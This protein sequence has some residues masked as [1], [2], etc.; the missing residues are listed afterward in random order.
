MQVEQMVTYTDLEHIK[1]QESYWF[2]RRFKGKYTPHINHLGEVAWLS[3]EEAL[4]Q[5][6]YFDY[7]PTFKQKLKYKF[8]ESPKVS[9]SHLPEDEK[10]YRLQ[11]RAYLEK[12]YLGEVQPDT[13]K[14]LPEKFFY[15]LSDKDIEDIH[16]SIDTYESLFQWNKKVMLPLIFVVCLAIFGVAHAINKANDYDGS[17]V[18]ESNLRGAA[19]YLNGEK[20]GYADFQKEISNLPPGEYRVE[21][22]KIGY[23]S[24]PVKVKVGED[25]APAKVFIPLKPLGVKNQGF[26]SVK[27]PF[28]DAKIFID[29]EFVG[30]LEDQRIIPLEKGDH[31]ITVEKAGYVTSPKSRWIHIEAGDT[32]AVEFE[33]VPKYNPSGK[34]A[35][36]SSNRNSNSA[37]AAPIGQG[38]ITVTANAIGA[39]IYL[40]GE[41]TGKESDHV[42]T[43]LPFGE[44]RI[45]LEKE[46]YRC[47]P[48]EKLVVVSYN[49]PSV[50]AQ[51]ELVKEFERVEISVQPPDGEIFLNGQLVG[52]GTYRDELKVGE[53][54]LSFGKLPGYNTPKPRTIRVSPNIPVNIS[55]SY[56]PQIQ[57]VVEVTDDGNKRIKGCDVVAG[58]T[59]DDRGFIPNNEVGPEIVYLEKT[60]NYYWKFGYAY[61]HRT[62]RGN[63]ALKVT[64]YLPKDYQ[65]G[66]RFTLN[67]YGAVSEERYPLSL[68][69]KS[70]IFI[71]LNGNVLSY[72]YKPKTIEDV[73]DVE[74]TS[75]DV[76][77]YLRPG[78][79][80]L[81]IAVSDKNNM[82]YYL[83]KIELNNIQ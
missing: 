56:F 27:A 9:L 75:W 22:R 2:F 12:K 72:Y 48:A 76:G 21:L 18:I 45:H 25:K 36:A 15:P 28:A 61:P 62:P 34:M 37:L 30:V 3:Q 77:E 70:E 29:D 26:V 13:R 52:K 47:V 64:L 68:S 33:I 51:F 20:R 71:K 73:G 19:I 53:Y 55:A 74:K 66:S 6:E 50:D 83:K 67:I 59:F 17:I 35:V 10:A 78:A 49:S 44:Y 24:Q 23:A 5:H 42:F 43:G 63:D 32:I 4:N 38:M 80:V 31:N 16:I 57:A 60:N 11:I 39:K 54:E 79:N 82:F 14:Q 69:K 41:D 1:A 58:Y 65:P 81:E 7:E 40:N 46:G 8:A